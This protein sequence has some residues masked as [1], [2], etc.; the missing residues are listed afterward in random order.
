MTSSLHVPQAI[1]AFFVFSYC[2]SWLFLGCIT[3]R[4]L[5]II[6]NYVY[7]HSIYHDILGYNIIVG[8]NDTNMGRYFTLIFDAASLRSVTGWSSRKL[9]QNVSPSISTSNNCPTKGTEKHLV[10]ILHGYCFQ[11]INPINY[12][13]FTLKSSVLC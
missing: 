12:I 10:Q 13:H 5:L 7:F 4:F 6:H 3:T 2:D 8:D 11:I 9:L 1:T